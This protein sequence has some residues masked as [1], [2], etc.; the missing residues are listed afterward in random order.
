MIVQGAKLSNGETMAGRD[1]SRQPKASPGRPT[2]KFPE[3]YREAVQ[4]MHKDGKTV[5]D[6]RAFLITNGHSV[7]VKVI[8]RVM[9]GTPETLQDFA[10]GDEARAHNAVGLTSPFFDDEMRNV[11]DDLIL[12]NRSPVRV[13]AWL[14]VSGLDVEIDELVRY[15]DE[16]RDVLVELS[17]DPSLLLSERVSQHLRGLRS[18][19]VHIWSKL[20][21]E[22]RYTAKTYLETQKEIGVMLKFE[23][24]ILKQNKDGKPED[25]SAHNAE[26][27]R[28]LGIVNA[29]AA[30]VDS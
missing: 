4:A 5:D 21:D 29:E 11:V 7:D 6:A 15:M 18:K 30:Q 26:I 2:R 23:A 13:R 22:Q 17:Q 25:V 27:E 1:L 16:R 28:K 20:P 19:A 3:Q 10:M 8:A 14:Y 9:A 12:D 24:E